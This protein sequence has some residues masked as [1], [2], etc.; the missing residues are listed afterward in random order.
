[1]NT[2]HKVVIMNMAFLL[3]LVING[4]KTD[5]NSGFTSSFEG[6]DIAVHMIKIRYSGMK[7]FI[8]SFLHEMWHQDT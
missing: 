3:K 7:I 1:M 8:K 6:I 2:N 5:P 4:G